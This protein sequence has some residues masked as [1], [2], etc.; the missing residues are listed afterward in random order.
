[1]CSTDVALRAVQIIMKPVTSTAT[2]WGVMNLIVTLR[3]SD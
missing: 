2:Y 3:N 1:M